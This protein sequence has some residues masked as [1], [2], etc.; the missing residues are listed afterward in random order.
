MS[1]YTEAKAAAV[2]RWAELIVCLAPQ[3]KEALERFPRHVKCPVHGGVDGFRLFKDFN[4][5]GGGICNTCGTRADGFALLQWLND[6]DARQTLKAVA[7]ELALPRTL[8]TSSA[9]PH[10]PAAITPAEANR[11]TAIIE[12]L[13]GE[14]MLL[15]IAADRMAQGDSLT[16]TELERVGLVA[17]RFRK[18]RMAL[19]DALNGGAA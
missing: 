6:W 8:P 10:A 12:A 1:T 16:L 2:G 5:T 14:L 11:I 18:G 13:S 17:E 15:E 19:L 3:S 7:T 4:E 9:A